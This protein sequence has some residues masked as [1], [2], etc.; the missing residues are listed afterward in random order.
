MVK[1][2][3]LFFDEVFMNIR[4]ESMG[5]LFSKTSFMTIQM[6]EVSR[7]IFGNRLWVSECNTWAD[8]SQQNRWWIFD[9]RCCLIILKRTVYEDIC[10]RKLVDYF[11]T[12]S[13]WMFRRDAWVDYFS[14]NRWL[15]LG[16]DAW[17]HCCQKHADEWK[18]RREWLRHLR[19]IVNGEHTGWLNRVSFWEKHFFITSILKP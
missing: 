5:W 11:P 13:L 18:G 12:N 7:L 15:I 10:E 14:R 9:W 2:D 16:W 19:V 3:L 8:Y 6:E 4:I 1:V 17:V